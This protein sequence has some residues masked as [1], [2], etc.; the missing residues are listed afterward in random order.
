MTTRGTLSRRHGDT[1]SAIILTMVV[2]AVLTGLG[3]TV[4]A[5]STDNLG[6]ARRDRQASSAL[7]NGE[8][9]VACS[10]TGNRIRPRLSRTARSLFMT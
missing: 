8:A 5:L 7:A 4:F 2:M 6:N 9:G 10:A 1:G 3:M